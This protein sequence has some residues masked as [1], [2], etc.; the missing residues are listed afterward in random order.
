[1]PR[2]SRR[3]TLSPSKT[4]TFLSSSSIDDDMD[5]LSLPDPPCLDDSRGNSHKTSPLKESTR[6]NS[7]N[8]TPDGNK[9]KSPTVCDTPDRVDSEIGSLLNANASLSPGLSPLM[10]SSPP[11][12]SPAGKGGRRGR[13][14]NKKRQSICMVSEDDV[15]ARKVLDDY[16]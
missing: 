15:Q 9:D 16:T 6:C 8:T 3:A 14:R 4:K 5:P 10:P 13:R 7:R 11:G 12:D 2:Q 1:M